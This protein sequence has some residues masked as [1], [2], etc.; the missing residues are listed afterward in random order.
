MGQI[1][2]RASMRAKAYTRNTSLNPSGVKIKAKIKHIEGRMNKLAKIP[3]AKRNNEQQWEMMQLSFD[4][5]FLKK[6]ISK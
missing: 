6:K 1:F 3:P 2:V 4:R 5:N